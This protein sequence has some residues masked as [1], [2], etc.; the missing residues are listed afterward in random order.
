MFM[1]EQKYTLTS[2]TH[3]FTLSL[4]RNKQTN[5]KLYIPLPVPNAIAT[6][7]FSRYVNGSRLSSLAELGIIVA[8]ACVP[9]FVAFPYRVN[10]FLSWEG[11]YRISQGQVPF[12]DF[13]MPMG[14]MYWV[15]PSFF[16]KVFGSQLITL[17]KAQ[18]FINII[19]GLAFRSILQS[20][21]VPKG[22]RLLSVLL[23]CLSFSFFNFWPWYNHTV[24]VY[25]IV[26]LAFLFKH[27]FSTDQKVG[28]GWLLLSALFTLFSFFTKQD[29]GGLGLAL[30]TTLL[31]CHSV[32]EK[33]WLPVFVYIGSVFLAGALF[34]FPYLQYNLAYWFN[35]GQAPHTAR[36][37]VYEVAD[38]F[39]SGSEWIKFYLLLVA[40]LAFTHYRNRKTQKVGKNYVLF[41]LLTT[42]ILIEAAVLQ[43]TSYTPPDNNIFYHA[44]AFAFILTSLSF[45]LKIDFLKTKPLLVCMLGVLLWWSGTYWK[46]FERMAK[47]IL[48]GAVAK[49][50]S[51]ENIVNKKTYKINPPSKDIAM[52]KWVFSD[53]KSFKKIYMPAPT[54]EGIKRLMN[55]DLVKSRKNLRVLNMTELTPLAAEIPYQL[56]S[57][58]GQPLWYHL[59]VSMFN[60]QAEMFEDR[61]AKKQ[62]D[63][64]LFEHVPTLN[65]FYPFRVRDSL[66]IHYQKRDS[67]I[68]PRRGETQGMIEVYTR[69]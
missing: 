64:V 20:L 23:Y 8:L 21:S 10:I 53:L 1:K 2:K 27:I 50:H 24:I 17:V 22:V 58:I 41:L 40:L 29:G 31:V 67:F 44:F 59:G 66:Q 65:N 13:G 33:K 28:W 16:F 42:G 35:Y 47:R 32:Y 60:K 69:Y 9:L 54:V 63:L 37:S 48:P 4:H 15:V 3:S 43:V 55:S 62:Y 34:I 36:L 51:D 52:S 11:A 39:F 12:R 61:I 56:E 46:Y 57:G 6:H 26:A 7:R 25:Q 45:Y 18:V 19:S 49:T 14:Y 30:C 5:T 68:A 38:L